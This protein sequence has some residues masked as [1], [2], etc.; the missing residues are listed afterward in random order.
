MEG[1]FFWRGECHGVLA[2]VFGSVPCCGGGGGVPQCRQDPPRSVAPA[3]FPKPRQ[4]GSE[5]RAAGSG[6]LDVAG[7]VR[8]ALL[9]TVN[10][11]GL[12]EGEGSTR[13]VDAPL[14]DVFHLK[15]LVLP[16]EWHPKSREHSWDFLS[17]FPG[18]LFGRLVTGGK[19]GFVLLK[20]PFGQPTTGRTW[21]LLKAVLVATGS[22][23]ACE[24]AEPA[25]GKTLGVVGTG[26]GAACLAPWDGPEYL[27]AV[28]RALARPCPPCPWRCQP[29]RDGNCQRRAALS[30]NRL[31]LKLCQKNFHLFAG[32]RM[33]PQL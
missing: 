10:A 4:T 22:S 32:K 12:L 6:R 2:R 23:S 1:F 5:G 24:E 7:R 9:V 19:R 20:H 21:L 31:Q 27:L 16:W 11:A 3:A 8:R 18:P 26:V 13:R 30:R 14:G 28:S 15:L 25:R 29:S 17:G 33:C